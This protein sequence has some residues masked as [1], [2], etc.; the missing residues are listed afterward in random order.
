MDFRLKSLARLYRAVIWRVS[1]L[2]ELRML[3]LS[4]ATAPVD[5]GCMQIGCSSVLVLVSVCCSLCLEAEHIGDF[6]F[7]VYW[8]FVERFKR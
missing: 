7:R 1:K 5:K 6:F 2:L 4:H 3:T 8:H